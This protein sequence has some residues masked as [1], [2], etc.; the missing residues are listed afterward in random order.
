M[1]VVPHSVSGR[2][3]KTGISSPASVVNTT[4]APSERPIQLVCITLTGSAQSIVEK[5]SSSSAYLVM[6]KNHCS[7]FRCSTAAPVRSSLPSM[8]CS[9]ASTVCRTGDQLTMASPR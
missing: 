9:L 4:S 3:V 2:V 5:S 1:N 8:T 7:I 6:A